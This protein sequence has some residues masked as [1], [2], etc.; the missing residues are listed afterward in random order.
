MK[1]NIL[2]DLIASIEK[3]PEEQKFDEVG[4]AME[5]P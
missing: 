4:L 3:N 5:E 1:P 2:V